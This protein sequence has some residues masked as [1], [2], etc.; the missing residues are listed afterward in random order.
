MATLA[1]INLEDFLPATFA[2]PNLTDEQFLA[3]C[4]LVRR[5]PEAEE[6]FP[7]FTPQFVIKVGSPDDRIARLRDKMQQRYIAAGVLL[8][9]LIDPFDQPEIG[10][11]RCTR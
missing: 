2:A 10:R 4:K 3:F 7:V 9:W 8:A 6:R 11:G 5:L 1:A